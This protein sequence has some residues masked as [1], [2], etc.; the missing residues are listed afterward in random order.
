MIRHGYARN[1]FHLFV[2]FN[3]AVSMGTQQVEAI[4]TYDV[5]KI[6]KIQFVK[7]RVHYA[8]SQ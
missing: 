2:Y 5:N 4:Y 6:L 8:Y 1:Y 7:Y 3:T